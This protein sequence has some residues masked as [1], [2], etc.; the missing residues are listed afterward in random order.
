MIRVL[1]SAALAVWI[2]ALGAL[3][4]PAVTSAAGR[5]QSSTSRVTQELYQDYDAVFAKYWKTKT[6]Q[7]VW[8][9]PSST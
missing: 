2:G 6:G 9:P 7:D 1:S 4:S 5:V 3:V 8:T